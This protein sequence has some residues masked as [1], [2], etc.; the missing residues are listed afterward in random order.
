MLRTFDRLLRSGQVDS[1]MKLVILGITAPGTRNIHSLASK[2]NLGRSVCFLEGLSEPEL[3]WCYTQCEAVVAPSLTEGFGLPVAEGLLAGCRIVCSDIPAHREV[4]DGKC[5][6]VALGQDAEK[7]FAEAIVAAL[8]EPKRLPDALPQ[9]S[10]STLAKEYIGL[11]RRLITSTI[12]LEGESA[13]VS[14]NVATSERQP[15]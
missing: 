1:K 7:T 13:S 2:L 3:Q 15:L 5:W 4:G 8:K 14:I 11:Y 10:A 9:F 6:F 12:P